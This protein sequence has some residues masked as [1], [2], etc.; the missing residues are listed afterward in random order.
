MP[1]DP[2]EPAIIEWNQQNPTRLI[3]MR[4]DAAARVITRPTR[5]DVYA[6]LARAAD[7]RDRGV[8]SDDEFE[9]EKQKILRRR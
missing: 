1:S 3:T 9:R 6:E 4:F 8:L 2:L 5:A 7:L